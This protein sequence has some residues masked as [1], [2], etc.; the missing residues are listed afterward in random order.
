[1]AA[2]CARDSRFIPAT[3]IRPCVNTIRSCLFFCT[4]ILLA[5]RNLSLLQVQEMVFDVYIPFYYTMK[6]AKRM[7][8]Y[9]KKNAA[10]VILLQEYRPA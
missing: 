4:M 7:H 8:I 5:S 1:M 3:I 2:S 9:A 6:S 10:C